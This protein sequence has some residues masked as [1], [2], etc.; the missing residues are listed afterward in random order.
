MSLK[1]L[2]RRKPRV[3][4]STLAAAHRTTIWPSRH[5]FTLRLRCRA[6]LIK[7]SALLVELSEALQGTLSALPDRERL[8]LRLRFERDMT[9]AEIAGAL[10]ISQMHVSRLLRRSLGRLSAA[11]AAAA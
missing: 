9:Q 1:P 6:R 7:L 3:A 5:R 8:I 4:S 2:R 11:G 10:G